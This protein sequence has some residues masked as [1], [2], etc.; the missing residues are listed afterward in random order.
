MHDHDIIILYTLNDDVMFISGIQIATD[1]LVLTVLT[2]W[3]LL[4]CISAMAWNHTD[5]VCRWIFPSSAAL[6]LILVLSIVHVFVAEP[7]SQM[8]LGSGLWRL[9]LDPLACWFVLL[10]GLVVTAVSAYS[11]S[12]FRER[13]AT[14]AGL[15]GLWY[16]LFLI[17][18][19]LVVLADSAYLLMLAWEGMAVTSYLLVVSNYRQATTRAAGLL[20][21]LMSQA[22]GYALLAGFFLL[23][24]Q[25]V[26]LP[27]DQPVTT[28]IPMFA[29]ASALALL[30]GLMKMGVV[31]LHTW[32]P[33]AHP[34]APS[35]VSALM[36][37][38]MLKMAVY[39]VMRWAL[40]A[41]PG[42]MVASALIVAGLVTGLFAVIHAAVQTDMKRLLAYSSMEH[43]GLIMLAIGLVVLFRSFGQTV[44]AVMLLAAVLFQVL[45]HAVFKSLLFLATGT[46]LHATGRRNLGYLGGL[47]KLMPWTGWVSLIGVLSAAGIPFFAG[48]VAE[49]IILQALI[50]TPPLGSPLL[51]MVLPLCGAL[52]ALI[53]ALAAYTMVKFYGIVFLGQPREISL[54][55]AH[56]SGRSER[57]AMSALAIICLLLGLLPTWIWPLL[58]D[59]ATHLL[60]QPVLS[61]AE[62]V[63]GVL[64]PMGLNRASYAPATLLL[65]L[66]SIVLLS[67]FVLRPFFRL[68]SRQAP[69]WD[70]GFGGLDQRMQDTAEGFGQPIRQI[71]SPFMEVDLHVPAPQDREPRYAI[72]VR[73]YTDTRLYQPL[74]RLY[75]AVVKASQFLEGD[76]RCSILWVLLSLVAMLLTVF[77]GGW[78]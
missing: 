67:L 12:Y 11:A 14:P 72:T 53:A 35:P 70:C 77:L 19:M 78:A 55:Q 18:M 25:G 40:L 39:V 20:Y 42:L 30:G 56:E 27:W 1:S 51:H 43:M 21:I 2:G 49:W 68:R 5:W 57:L 10:L 73:D 4:G 33:E 16:H 63:M 44:W 17:S 13:E 64:T 52:V 69:A 28:L 58:H 32:L 60:A 50:L 45:A 22:G 26:V 66:L 8:V 38:V 15:L 9:R 3:F 23:P 59:L 48:F 76:L 7:Y 41:H 6:G 62:P 31:P 34:A 37:G 75:A 46:V 24:G 74:R 71:F 47:L 29:T 54:L 65:M 61:G 36:S